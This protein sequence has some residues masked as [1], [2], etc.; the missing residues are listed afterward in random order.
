MYA[1]DQT[2]I[3]DILGGSDIS[4]LATQWFAPDSP[5]YSEKVAEAWPTNDPEQAQALLQE[6]INDPN[7]SDGKGVGEP[8]VLEHNILP[9]PSVI[10]M[11]LGYQSMWEALGY[12]HNMHQVEVA[13][14]IDTNLSGDFMINT[15]RFGD[16]DDPCIT[17]RNNFGDPGR[18]RRTSPTSRTRSSRPTSRRC[19]RAPTSTPGT[20]RS[21]TS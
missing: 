1:I 14:I 8:V 7:R 20:R 12:V 16:Q 4:P 2:A 6:Y 3:L 21:R 17:L 11:G 19:A 5:W 15:S 10:E 9:D 18:R 13:V